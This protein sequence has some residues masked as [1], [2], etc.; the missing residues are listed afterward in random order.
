MAETVNDLDEM[1]SGQFGNMQMKSLPAKR[2]YFR[3][4]NDIAKLMAASVFRLVA[5]MRSGYT[6]F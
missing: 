6:K 4:I 3:P 2:L 5:R 1:L